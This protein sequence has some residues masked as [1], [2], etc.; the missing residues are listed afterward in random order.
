MSNLSLRWAHWMSLRRK[1]NHHF[2]SHL[3]SLLFRLRGRSLHIRRMR[4]DKQRFSSLSWTFPF[5][6][7]RNSW[8][9]RINPSLNSW[10]FLCETWNMNAEGQIELFSIH[11]ADWTTV[12]SQPRLFIFTQLGQRSWLVFFTQW[13]DERDTPAWVWTQSSRLRRSRTKRKLIRTKRTRLT[14]TSELFARLVSITWDLERVESVKL[15][16]VGENWKKNRLKL[17]IIS[18]IFP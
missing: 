12:A 5:L 18:K 16:Q 11:A 3:L 1:A 9:D 4:I 13:R 15:G 8:G 10:G 17:L 2:Y 14:E 7:R 6:D